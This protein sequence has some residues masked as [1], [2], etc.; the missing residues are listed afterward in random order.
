MLAA[1]R[2]APVALALLIVLA[3]CGGAP[4][5]GT[6]TND[7]A[8]TPTANGTATTTGDASG[9]VT[10]ERASQDGAVAV[11]NGTL[12]VNA[13]RTFARVQ[14]LMGTDVDPRPVELRNLSEWRSSLPRVAAAPINDA[15]GFENVSANWSE[16]TGVTK[17]TGYV[18]VHPGEGS[19][20]EV[21][22]VLAHEF[23]HS[24]QFQANMF[25]WLDELRTGRV[26]TDEAKTL[27]ALQEGGAVYVTDAYTQQYLD[28]QRNSAF[29]REYM[30]KSPTHWS[31]L[32]PYY[33]GSQYVA[34]RIDS[35]QQLS[36]VYDNRP[37]TTEQILHNETRRE[38]PPAD[39]A[40]ES[41]VSA[42]QWQYLGNNTLGEMTTRGALGT[43]LTQ[44]RAAEA[45]AGW[46]RDEIAIFR[47]TGGDER[48][49]WA[50]VHRWDDASE[51]DEAAS[52]LRTFAERRNDASTYEFAVTRVSDG[53][54]AL[55]FGDDAFVANATVTGTTS[56]VSVAVGA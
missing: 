53:T 50:W 29:A 42:S 13:T 41:T 28:V 31:A 25:P 55:V 17:F 8:G 23:T 56:N 34:S 21:E 7:A 19:P 2:L 14:S 48:Y 54:T 33:F 5:N 38:E 20:Q 39:L 1:N 49:G 27:R 35:P 18:Y 4:G 22:R 9:T 47:H 44:S 24:I 16:P 15:L 11:E 40:V 43:E 37:N 32:A 30:S 36:N 45:A 6:A 46:G 51:A 12:R 52:A 10:P 3:G 26:T